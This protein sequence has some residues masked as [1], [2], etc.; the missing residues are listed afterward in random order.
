MSWTRPEDL[1]AQVQRLWDQGRLLSCA[2]SLESAVDGAD[3]AIEF[4]LPLKLRRP[5]ARE[6]GERFDT[7]RSWIEALESGSRS[8][9]GAGYEI[10]WEESNNRQLGRNRRPIGVRLPT[11]ADALALIDKAG[12]AALFDELAATTLDR[13]PMLADW[14]VKKPLTVLDHAPDWGRI[15]DCLAWFRDRKS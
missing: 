15:L 3:R 5:S 2:R 10:V 12:E 9:L 14:L 7:V 1:A 11:Y 6:L 8:K 13:F 4:P